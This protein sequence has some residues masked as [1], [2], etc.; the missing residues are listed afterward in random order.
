MNISF[1]NNLNFNALH[2]RPDLLL[3]DGEKFLFSGFIDNH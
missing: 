3:L 1:F 2:F